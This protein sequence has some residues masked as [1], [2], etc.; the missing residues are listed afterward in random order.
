MCCAQ[1]QASGGG[2][3]G[4]SGAGVCVGGA[5][6]VTHQAREKGCFSFLGTPRR[7]MSAKFISF[8]YLGVGCF[9]CKMETIMPPIFKGHC[10]G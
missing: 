6:Q 1:W 7:K 10:E 5:H 3:L 2:A 8:D 9:M 4:L